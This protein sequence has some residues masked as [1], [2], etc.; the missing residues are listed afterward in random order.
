[1][2]VT[3]RVRNEDDKLMVF[4]I[5]NSIQLGLIILKEIVEFVNYMTFII[6]AKNKHN[7]YKIKVIPKCLTT[8]KNLGAHGFTP[9]LSQAQ[10]VK[11]I[12]VLLNLSHKIQ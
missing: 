10:K 12:F 8:R 9:E 4:S 2:S 1:M 11:L 5:Q 6:K 3:H 7:L